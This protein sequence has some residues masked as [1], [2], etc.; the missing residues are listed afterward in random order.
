ML[1]SELLHS[2][3]P[4]LHLSSKDSIVQGKVLYP[5]SILTSLWNSQSQIEYDSL[6]STLIIIV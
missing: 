4:V 3:F 5:K 1:S 2:G 6:V